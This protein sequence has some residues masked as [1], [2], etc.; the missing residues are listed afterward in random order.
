MYAGSEHFVLALSHDEVVYGKRS[1]LSKMPGDWWKQFASLRA[2]YGY[3][4]ALPGK[5]LLF[6]GGE[7]G[8][9][10]EWDH[11]SELDWK[12]ENEEMHAGLGRYVRDL[13]ALYRREPALHELDAEPHGFAWIDCHDHEGST[14]TFIAQRSKGP[15]DRRHLQLLTQ[16]APRIPHRC[17][18]RRVLAGDPER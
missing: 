10:T 18:A 17:S 5:K 1:L 8:Q 15:G 7:L 12:L 6:M 9:W 4:Y 3:M 2:L 14:L 13:N 16:T 11:E